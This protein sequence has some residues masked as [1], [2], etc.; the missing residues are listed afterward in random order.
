MTIC[1]GDN[2][3]HKAINYQ[4]LERLNFVFKDFYEVEIVKSTIEF[5]EPII[6]GVCITALGQV[7]YVEAV[8]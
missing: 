3:A 4:F 6:L 7:E 8:L 1:L 2:K 5:C